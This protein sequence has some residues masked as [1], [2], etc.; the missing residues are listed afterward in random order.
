MKYMRNILLFIVFVAGLVSLTY[1]LKEQQEPE[2]VRINAEI[3]KQ[4]TIDMEKN[5]TLICD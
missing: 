5:G 4:C 1:I 3:T 2:Y